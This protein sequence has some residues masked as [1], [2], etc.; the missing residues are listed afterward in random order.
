M[1]IST[2]VH[3]SWRQ[4]VPIPP[5]VYYHRAEAIRL[6]NENLSSDFMELAELTI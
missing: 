4:G 2:A 6:M 1:I 5:E 3:A